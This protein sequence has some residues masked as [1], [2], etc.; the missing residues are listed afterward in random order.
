LQQP[1]V[2]KHFPRISSR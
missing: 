1:N 2:L